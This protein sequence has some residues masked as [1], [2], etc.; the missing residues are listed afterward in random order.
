[1]NIDILRVIALFDIILIHTLKSQNNFD[2]LNFLFTFV[3]IG[4]NL[5]IMISG[6]LLLSKEEGAITFYKK[7]FFSIVP[8][9]VVWSIIYIIYYKENPLYVIAGYRYAAGHLWYIPMITGLY[10]ITPWLRKILK[11]CEKE[12]RIVVLMWFI[13]NILNPALI[14]FKL[15]F[16]NLSAFPITGF[17]GYYILGYYIKKYKDKINI[18]YYWAAYIAGFIFT[19]GVSW[20]YMKIV[21]KK[22]VFFYDKN[23]ISVFF[24]SVSFFII[25]IKADLDYIKGKAAKAVKFLSGYSYHVYLAHLLFYEI[26]MR[27]TKNFYLI[28]LFCIGASYL[29]AY[30]Y[31]KAEKILG[32]I[33]WKTKT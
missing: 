33:I 17:L 21:G 30:I 11:Y 10:I 3:S 20:Y 29:T 15:P 16:L 14:F 18:N 1:M 32:K 12:T 31:G 22:N 28:T 5:F 24:M 8:L 9:Y 27:I 7:R 23:S 4:I 2:I 26:G 13:I 6:Y 19:F 25:I